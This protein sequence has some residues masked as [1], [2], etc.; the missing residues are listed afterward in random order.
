[1]RASLLCWL[2]VVVAADV[3]AATPTV[4]LVD[5][6]V[7]HGAQVRWAD[8]VSGP[9]DS[10]L[11]RRVVCA[12]PAPGHDRTWTRQELLRE[13]V[14]RGAQPI[15]R[16]VGSDTVR[17]VR[18]GATLAPD[19]FS[20]RV[21]TLL[22]SQS[23]PVGAL[24]HEYEILRVPSLRVPRAD[25]SV[26]LEDTGPR[27]GRGAVAVRVDDGSTHG[28][29]AYV[30]VD[31]SVR[32][33][34][35][36]SG[37]ALAADSPLG[38]GNAVA[39]TIWTDDDRVFDRRIRPDEADGRWAVIRSIAGGQVLRRGDV[40]A[41]PVVHRGENVHWV[42]ERSG[43]RVQVRARARNDGAVG[44]WITVESPF[45]N[46]LRRVVVVGPGRVADHLPDPPVDAATGERV[47]TTEEGRS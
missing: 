45:D 12:S 19:R 38:V 42:V 40:R 46:R 9:M 39:D 33:V 16:L 25:A 18:P 23:P 21:R 27:V 1:M 31:R 32:V 3:P 28:R 20:A 26:Q 29:R 24:D 43:L 14:R 37:R 15:P 10:D 22:E 2:L 11:G 47:G 35:L 44:E 6:A 5:E 34:V 41:T 30:T 17:I 4:R 36:R 7:V 13:L 8:L